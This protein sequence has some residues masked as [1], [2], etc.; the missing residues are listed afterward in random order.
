MSSRLIY[1]FHAI[2]AKLRHDP[3]AVK[4]ILIDATRQDGRAR[5]LLQHAELQAVKVI[6]CDGKR[7]DDMA[8][9]RQ[10]RRS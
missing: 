2:T 9:S 4:E 5:D 8:A 6:A 1:G 7:L 3:S 10:Q